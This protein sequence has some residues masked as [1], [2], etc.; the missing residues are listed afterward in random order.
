MLRNVGKFLCIVVLFQFRLLFMCV[1]CIVVWICLVLC[2]CI[3]F[4]FSCWY[5]WI[6]WCRLCSLLYS[7]VGVNDGV[8]WLMVIVC[9]CWCVWIVLLMLFWMYGQNIG[10]LLSVCSGQLFIVSL[11]FLLGSYFWVLWVLKWISVLVLKFLWMNWQIVRQRWF[12]G[13]VLLWQVLF[14][15]L[16]CGGCGNSSRLF[17]CVVGN[18]K[19][20]W[21]LILC[22]V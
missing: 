21:L 8:W 4:L 9:L 14:G 10:R 11:W 19:C 16:V 3:V 20:C 6:N 2:L 15:W 5:L 12:G 13:I 17:R 22:K 18:M 7:L 1:V